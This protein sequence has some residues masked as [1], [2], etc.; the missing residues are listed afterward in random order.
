MNDKCEVCYWTESCLLLQLFKVA[1][2]L[3][4][5]FRD[6]EFG[7]CLRTIPSKSQICKKCKCKRG[8]ELRLT[9]N[10]NRQGTAYQPLPQ[11][12]FRLLEY[13]TASLIQHFITLLD[14]FLFFF[15]MS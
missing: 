2:E 13:G 4:T 3:S 1:F 10:V 5:A 6:L 15:V 9:N 11:R 8:G 14:G 7:Y 12:P